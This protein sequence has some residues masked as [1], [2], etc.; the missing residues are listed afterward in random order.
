MSGLSDILTIM[1]WLFGLLLHN[2]FYNIWLSKL[3]IMNVHDEGYSRHA[4]YPL[5]SVMFLTALFDQLMKC[6]SYEWRIII[7]LTGY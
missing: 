5:Y 1:S 3:L 6:F 7:F 4:S 2:N